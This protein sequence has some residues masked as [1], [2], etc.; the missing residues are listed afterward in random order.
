MEEIWKKITI[1]D[2]NYSISSMGRVRNDLTNKILNCSLNTKGYVQVALWNNGEKT[3]HRVHRLVAKEFIENNFNKPQVNH[4]NGLKTDNRI[5]NLEWCNNSENIKHSYKIGT[6]KNSGKLRGVKY[7]HSTGS[8]HPL[9]KLT[10][11]N[12]RFIRNNKTKFKRKEL[13]D[14]FGVSQQSISN[15]INNISWTHI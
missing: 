14:M 6:M 7:L 3:I 9:A 8:L 5:E 13:Q 15:I 11:D 2:C 4:I 10:E 12:V 1:V